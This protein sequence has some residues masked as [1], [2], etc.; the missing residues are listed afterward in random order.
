MNEGRNKKGKL[1]TSAGL[2]AR[3]QIPGFYSQS[4]QEPMMKDGNE[5]HHEKRAHTSPIVDKVSFNDEQ[6]ENECIQNGC[7][8]VVYAQENNVPCGL[9]IS[10]RDL[11]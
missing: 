1:P 9:F 10:W 4:S 11:S 7:C 5:C 2:L 6:M 8:I 3:F